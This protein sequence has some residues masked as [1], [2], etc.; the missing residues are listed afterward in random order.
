[1]AR[2][3]SYSKTSFHVSGLN[4]YS[5]EWLDPFARSQSA[6]FSPWPATLPSLLAVDPEP[7]PLRD[8]T[9]AALELWEVQSL[10]TTSIPSWAAWFLRIP[11]NLMCSQV[12]LFE[13]G[14]LVEGL[15]SATSIS[16]GTH[17]TLAVTNL[18]MHPFTLAVGTLLSHAQAMGII[19]EYLGA[20]RVATPGTW[21][22]PEVPSDLNTLLL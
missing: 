18:P 7:A 11:S 17:I 13:P 8:D 2:T 12:T 10:K 20:V 6:E 5:P 9:F 16:E 21:I 1:M 3:P 4:P 19:N 15:I 14:H 22:H